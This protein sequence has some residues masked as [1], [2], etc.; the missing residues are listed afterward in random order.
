MHAEGL[1]NEVAEASVALVLLGGDHTTGLVD[2]LQKGLGVKRFDR[3]EVD[4][5][6]RDALCGQGV[7]GLKGLPNQV[8]GGGDGHVAAFEQHVGLANDKG[9]VGGGE[10]GHLGASEAQINRAMVVGKGNGCSLRLV[11]VRGDDDRHARKH[12]HQ[13][14]VFKNLVRR[15][16]FA[17]GK[18]CVRGADFYV[19]VG[20]GDALA[21][22]VVDP[23]GREVGKGSGERNPAANG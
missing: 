19:F 14:N 20:V 1:G 3:G 15:A 5:L 4:D 8:A 11:V 12:F 21:D 7:G 13:P 23:S 10:V 16:V 6:R 18:A 2:G 9:L 22:L 17:Q